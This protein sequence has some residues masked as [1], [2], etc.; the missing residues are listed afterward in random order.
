MSFI[1]KWNDEKVQYQNELGSSGNTKVEATSY[2]FTE[3][4]SDITSSI[5]SNNECTSNLVSSATVS[6]PEENKYEED[7]EE[8]YDVECDVSSGI[9]SKI[10]EL[11][12]TDIEGKRLLTSSKTTPSSNKENA[13]LIEDKNYDSNLSNTAEIYG[14]VVD[15]IIVSHDLKSS[16]QVNSSRKKLEERKSLNYCKNEEF[17]QAGK[18]VLKDLRKTNPK[19]CKDVKN[20]TYNKQIWD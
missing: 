6:K 7:N 11:N 8:E 4:N 16:Y 2:K 18:A 19:L 1:R 15:T 14:K 9:S 17:E 13:S 20:L 10:A 5:K 3:H 12:Y